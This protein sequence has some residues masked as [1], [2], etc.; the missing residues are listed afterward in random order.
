M[1]PLHS[2]VTQIFAVGVVAVAL[3]A[4]ACERH[5][6]RTDGD[7]T[8]ATL[9]TPSA[10]P[11][12]STA[13]VADARHMAPSPPAA[14]VSAVHTSEQ[15]AIGRMPA[16]AGHDIVVRNC[17]ICHSPSLIEQQHKDTAGWNKTITQMVAWGA[18]LSAAE[19]PILIAYLA[20]HF[21][22]RGPGAP[23]RQV[24]P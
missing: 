18:P 14:L 1:R 11:A 24:P 5:V 9:I 2:A 22:A 3:V 23:A 12:A 16:G 15:T 8:A 6:A 17:L 10:S 4:V 21:R 19:K 13:S 20:E 7:T